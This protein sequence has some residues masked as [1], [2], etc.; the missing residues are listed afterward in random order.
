MTLSWLPSTS[1]GVM[2]GDYIS[3]SIV[4][5]GAVGPFA[6]ASAP[7]GGL[8]DEAMFVPA[9]GVPVTGGTYAAATGPVVSNSSDHP[10]ST[11]PLTA[12]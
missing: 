8:F 1:Q 5:R 7:S 9:A 4:T 12:Q 3:T 11:V 2:V 6:V 10:V